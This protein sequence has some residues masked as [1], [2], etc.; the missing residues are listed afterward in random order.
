MN[1]FQF[2]L[3]AALEGRNWWYVSTH[4]LIGCI[5]RQ[6]MCQPL[7]LLDVGCGTGGLL[8]HLS[9]LGALQGIDPDP[10][11][12][13]VARRRNRLRNK[14]EFFVMDAEGLERGIRH[15]LD[16]ITC[17]D[18]LYHQSVMD[19]RRA[20]GIFSGKLRAGGLLVLQVPAF[21]CLR[22]AHDHAVQGARRFHRETL[23][24]A[25]NESGFE[26]LLCSHRFAWLF[27]GLLAKRTWDR[28]MGLKNP[29]TNDLNTCA[30]LPRSWLR[31][32]NAT[33]LNLALTENELLLSGMSF[34]LGS[35]LFAVAR[36]RGPL[37][38]GGAEHTVLRENP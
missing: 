34:A 37:N 1:P 3:L 18:V 5:L 9:A 38:A 25:L 29:A 35:S 27:P 12:I 8:R 14:A 10:A 28:W 23:V 16:C 30:A 17:V 32:G 20:L 24:A 6:Y 7:S 33:L 11:A 36:K 31:L 2:R 4:R 26:V 19:W 22:G 15:T 13:Q 21:E